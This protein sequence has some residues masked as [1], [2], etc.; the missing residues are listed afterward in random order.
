MCL[1]NDTASI[2]LA[3]L[4]CKAICNAYPIEKLIGLDRDTAKWLLSPAQ[5]QRWLKP[6]MRQL[7]FTVCV[8]DRV[9]T[10]YTHF[11]HERVKS[12]SHQ[13]LSKKYAFP[14]IDEHRC[15]VTIKGSVCTLSIMHSMAEDEDEVT[16]SDNGDGVC[17]FCELPG[18][19][20]MATHD[21]TIYCLDLD[22]SMAG[23]CSDF[24]HKQVHKKLDFQ[25]VL[26]RIDDALT[27]NKFTTN[28]G[29]TF[30][31]LFNA[32]TLV[33]FA[34]DQAPVFTTAPDAILDF[35]VINNEAIVC[36]TERAVLRLLFRNRF[37]ATVSIPVEN[38]AVIHVIPSLRSVWLLDTSKRLYRTGYGLTI[39]KRLLADRPTRSLAC[40]RKLAKLNLKLKEAR[41]ANTL[42]ALKLECV[43]LQYHALL[44]QINP[45]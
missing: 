37:V 39:G 38:V 23:I 43:Q 33:T 26:S 15:I 24:V 16:I 35:W 18:L 41:A 45:P 17:S 13:P 40:K 11:D 5:P 22:Q 20:Y 8:H 42:L 19:L 10:V 28:D 25:P 1:L 3:R 44:S 9:I 36:W 2:K 31:Y 30:A 32:N 21:G 34:Q 12:E 7:D 6:D 4:S 27:I 14:S 29:E